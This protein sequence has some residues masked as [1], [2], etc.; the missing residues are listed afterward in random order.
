MQATASGV[1]AGTFGPITLA[2]GQ[3]ISGDVVVSPTL[4]EGQTRIVLTWGAAPGDL[5]SHLF[6]PASAGNFHLF[7]SRRTIT[8]PGESTAP[9]ATLDVDQTRGFGPETVTLLEQT[10]GTYVF[11][12]HDYTNRASGS[13]AAMSTSG[14]RVRVFRGSAVVAEF[15]VPNQPGTYWTVFT[16]NGATITPV[17]TMSFVGTPAHPTSGLELNGAARLA[18]P[19]KATAPR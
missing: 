11:A 3:T 5:D 6:G 15:A 12:V 17:N 18:A 13:S 14:A 7:F 1:I 16:M 2:P 4:A 19:A 8:R 10:A 9:I